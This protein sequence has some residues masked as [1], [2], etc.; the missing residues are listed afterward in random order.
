MDYTTYS[1]ELILAV[2]HHLA[3]FGYP[4]IDLALAQPNHVTPVCLR[5]L[6][7]LRQLVPLSSPLHFVS[8]ATSPNT[9]L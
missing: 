8:S 3:S 7:T 2:S 1:R 4:G 9:G 5:S 6:L